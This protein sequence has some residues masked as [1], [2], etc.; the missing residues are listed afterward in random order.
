M[1]R[2]K[3]RQSVEFGAKLSASCFDDY[4]FL[5]HLNWENYN[6]SKETSAIR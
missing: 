5:D 2:G 3:A 4:V 1:V 6:E